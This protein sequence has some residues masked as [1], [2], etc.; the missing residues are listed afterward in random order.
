MQKKIYILLGLLLVII[1]L[2]F[3]TY[4]FVFVSNNNPDPVIEITPTPQVTPTVSKEPESGIYRIFSNKGEEIQILKPTKFNEITSPLEIEGEAKGTWFFEG[5]FPIVIEDL[6]GNQ[7]AQVPAQSTEDWMTEDWVSFRVE[8]NFDIETDTPAK[9][10]LKKDNPSGLPE[11][12]DSAIIE[13]II[14]E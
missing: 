12:D 7:I 3:I 1:I 5:S 2:G 8:I 10:I 11:N 4:R 6:S 9:I 14:V 13:T